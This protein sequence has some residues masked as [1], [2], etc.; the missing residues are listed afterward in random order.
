MLT[1]PGRAPSGV[2]VAKSP[3]WPQAVLFDLD[4][5]LVDSVPD[6]TA[7]VNRLL[8]FNGLGRLDVDDVRPMIGNGVKKLVQRAFAAHSVE[9]EGDRLTFTTDR[10]MGIYR[11][12]LTD[13]TTLMTGAYE[14][15]AALDQ[16]GV[17]IA[18]VTNKPESL[19]RRILEHFGLA[20]FVGSVIGG[21]TGPARKPA[22]DMLLQALAEFG[23]SAQDALLVG[24]SPA[25]INAAKAVP[26]ASI[27][28]R[29]GYTTQPVENLGAD[30]V[31]DSLAWLSRAIQTLRETD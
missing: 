21:D 4:G 27:A 8:E 19:S 2:P 15:I 26:M 7:S 3:L 28:V 9:L 17:R 14:A 16:S 6:L 23:V 1:K 30:Q 22:P 25:D 20:E 29:G 10:M 13:N 24:D 11:E 31:I 12:H 18:V 5:T